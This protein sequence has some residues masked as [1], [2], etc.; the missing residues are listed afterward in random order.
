MNTWETQLRALR[1]HVLRAALVYAALACATGACLPMV[2]R[3]AMR[4]VRALHLRLVATSL[5][6]VVVQDLKLVLT[7]SLVAGAPYFLWEAWR[8]V[9][10]GLTPGE[11]R[12]ARASVIA[13]F[14]LFVCGAAFAWWLVVPRLVQYLSAI[15]TWSHV[16]L[17]L[18]YAS[19]VSFVSNV[20]VAFGLAFELPLAAGIATSLGLLS[21][22]SL[23]AKRRY[24]YFALVVVGVIISP[25]ELIAHLSV[26]V[27]LFALYELSIGVSAIVE[28]RSAKEQPSSPALEKG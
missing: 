4:P 6:E 24:A 8:F 16:E 22:A 15:A 9:A 19:Y 11:R 28:R 20:L 26:T 14:A 17:Y 12:R 10:P 27:P 13:A 25:P 23:R 3:A 1:A 7:V 5:D 2:L 18:R 21:P